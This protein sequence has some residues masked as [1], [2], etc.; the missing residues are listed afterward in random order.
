MLAIYVDVIIVPNLLQNTPNM[1][2][3]SATLISHMSDSSSPPAT[4]Y[5]VTAAITGLLRMVRD[6]PCECVCVCMCVS[7]YV[8]VHVCT[9]VSVCVHVCEYVQ[10]CASVCV[11]YT[12][13]NSQ[14]NLSCIF[15]KYTR[16]LSRNTCQWSG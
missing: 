6:G 10:V 13:T 1:A 11:Q 3:S 8:R 2:S 16:K 4:A 15:T 14:T 12:D 5:P 7:V 9:C